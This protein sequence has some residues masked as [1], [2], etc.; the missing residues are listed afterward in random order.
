M[1]NQT[2]PAAD[3]RLDA[4][5]ATLVNRHARYVDLDIRSGDIRPGVNPTKTRV[6]ECVESVEFQLAHFNRPAPA[7]Y[8]EA[9]A[10][11]AEWLNADAD[12]DADDDDENIDTKILRAWFGL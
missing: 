6:A 3:S 9:K 5:I 4:Y 12:D 7:R 8:T 10:R 2:N 1:T 11:Y